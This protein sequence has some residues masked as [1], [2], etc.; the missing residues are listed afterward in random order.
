[1]DRRD[2]L[3]SGTVSLLAA[4]TLGLPARV[5]AG[6][7]ARPGQRAVF[8]TPSG[9]TVPRE[10]GVVLAVRTAFGGPHEPTPLGGRYRLSGAAG[11]L[12]LEAELLA[13]WLARIPLRGAREGALSIEGPAG[14]LEVLAGA[15]SFRGPEAPRPRSAVLSRW[16]GR[17]QPYAPPGW[18]VTASLAVAVPS[19]VVAVLVGERS[20]GARRASTETQPGERSLV[21]ERSAG[22]CGIVPPAVL[23]LGRGSEVTLAYVD[24]VGRVSAPS[25]AVRVTE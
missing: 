3:R 4:T 7:C 23:S 17:A 19:R 15:P 16:E 24:E 8:L 18:S 21:L 22:R 1:M 20:S 10:G 2:F 9:A 5:R 12:E 11:T 14:S 25:A 6:A 13:P